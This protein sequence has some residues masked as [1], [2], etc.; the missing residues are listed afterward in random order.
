MLKV[1][2][3][4]LLGTVIAIV[5][6]V[7]LMHS[8]VAN[9]STTHHSLPIPGTKTATSFAVETGMA[10]K[11]VQ[12]KSW[13][14]IEEHVT[15]KKIPPAK[16]AWYKN[17]YNSDYV[18]GETSNVPAMYVDH[19]GYLCHDSASPSGYIK[20]GGGATGADCGNISAPI[21]AEMPH[22]K[23]VQPPAKEINNAAS[24]QIEVRVSVEAQAKSKLY[25]GHATAEGFA[26]DVVKVNYKAY[27]A[28]KSRQAKMSLFI[29]VVVHAADRAVAKTKVS[30]SPKTVTQPVPSPVPS[31][32]QPPVTC[33]NG[34]TMVNG[35][36]VAPTL[37]CPT[38]YV[39][40]SNGTC[41]QQTNTAE[42]AC[43][44]L[45]GTWTGQNNLCTINQ[46]NGVCSVNIIINGSG[47]TV[48]TP[49]SGIC[50]T[51]TT[52]PPPTQTIT[53]N[54]LPEENDI[55]VGDNSGDICL[56]VNASDPGGSI[57]IDPGIGSVSSTG[58]STPQSSYTVSPLTAG[59]NSV[60]FVLYAPDDP[61]SSPTSM[62][63]NYDATLGSVS[64]S[65]PETFGITYPS[66]PS[67]TKALASNS[68]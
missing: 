22:Y 59:N 5:P 52:P 29:H 36:C 46:Q 17:F 12:T 28:A 4:S 10:T 57:T 58:S 7:M 3:R 42:L 30:C 8:A 51:T 15:S 64:D 67:D 26:T 40:G 41:V 1:N 53:I 33:Q 34:A 24:A 35:T 44:A 11:V 27:E 2:N 13:I 19:H 65:V 32:V 14:G 6:T 20:E 43:E 45:G 16:C 62:T 48:T 66:R 25:C 68:L 54:S 50:D 38:G 23:L 18:L 63:V 39:V 60:C 47:D 61:T 49:V 9:A 55:P 37:S 31:P 21:E 56:N